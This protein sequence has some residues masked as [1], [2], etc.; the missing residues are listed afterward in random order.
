MSGTSMADL[1][2]CTALRVESVAVRTSSALRVRTGM[3]P[4]RTARSMRALDLDGSVA[5]LG[6]AGGVAPAVQVGDVVVATE[7]RPGVRCPSAPLLAGELRRAGFRVHLGP[8]ATVESLS[9][10]PPAG[11]LAVDMESA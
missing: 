4:G 3:G 10:Q 1:T 2:I 5:M 9:S 8:I 7:V 11:V 6:V